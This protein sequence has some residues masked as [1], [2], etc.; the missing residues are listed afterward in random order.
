[1]DFEFT[2]EQLAMQKMAREYAEKE[3]APV[4]ADFDEKEEMP[5]DL[6]RRMVAEGF[7]SVNI[8]EEYGGAG[9][10][11]ITV[12]LVTEELG[13]G[14]AGI[15]TGVGANSLAMLP[16]LLAGSEEQKKKYLTEL[17][18]GKLASFCLTEPNA[19]S[20]VSSILTTA[21]KKGSEYVINGTKCFITNGTYADYYV[22]FAVVDPKRGARTLTPFVLEKGTP[23]LDA[24]KKEKKMG[25]RA[26][27]T[28][29]VVFENVSVPQENMLG[30]E[31]GGFRVAMETFDISRPMIASMAVGVARA[32]YEAA[33]NY[34][35]ERVQFGKPII[36]QQAIQFM[37]AD[38]A[39]EI[40]AA[41]SLIFRAASMIGKGEKSISAYAAMA[42][43]YAGDMAM[44]V[45]V[46]ALQ[47]LGGYGYTRDYP[48]EKYM[49]DAKIMQIYEGTSQ[50]QRL[51]IANGII[52]R[53]I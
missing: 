44:R 5:V 43:A 51:I 53:R 49:R 7:S 14:C 26:S 30:K 6:V 34:A 19:G 29:V 38:M 13:R 42:K 52:G 3:L 37:L 24:S 31:Y 28:A 45:T 27:N 12:C 20:D 21:I 39:M 1:M 33:V 9:M 40:E 16:I 48:L 36:Q 2:T 8:P 17:C 22:V 10:D 32:A 4:A 47:V 18:N 41:R 46:D 50:I 23:G 11:E 15:T 35:R 25:I